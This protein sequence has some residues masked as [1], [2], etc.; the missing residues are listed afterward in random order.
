M[1]S[2]CNRHFIATCS[3]QVSFSASRARKRPRDVARRLG[4]AADVL[5]CHLWV[6][7]MVRGEH[8]A[9][10]L[11][12]AMLAHIKTQLPGVTNTT[13]PA[14]L[15][16][17][18]DVLLTNANALSFWRK[19]LRGGTEMPSSERSIVICAELAS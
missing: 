12:D 15:R 2:P 6:D 9:T 19:F 14:S 11:L 13:Q 7:R 10:R 16:L 8:H 18:A 17:N 1:Q 3:L 5:V 4:I